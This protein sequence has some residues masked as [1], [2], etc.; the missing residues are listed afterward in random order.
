MSKKHSKYI[1][2]TDYFN[3][4]LIVL[5][6]TSDTI[7]LASFGTVIGASVG[8]T[9]AIFSLAFSFSTGIEKKH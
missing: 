8:I 4:F 2:S 3:K 9:S 7:S 1:A 6:A 5:S